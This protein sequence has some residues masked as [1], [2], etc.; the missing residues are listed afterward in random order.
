MAGLIALVLATRKRVVAGH[1]A[2]VVDVYA[3]FL[4]AFV[5][6]ARAFL[7]AALLAAGIISARRQ[8][9][10]FDHLVHVAAAAFDCGLL[11]AWRAIAQV[12]FAGAVMWMGGLATAQCLAAGAVAER[13]RVEAGLA[14]FQ[15]D[16][17]L[18]AG[19][20]GRLFGACFA[21]ATFADVAAVLALV[22]AA[23]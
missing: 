11:V 19:T 18:A 10:A 22:I 5:L 20:G 17:H 3:A 16:R 14:L 8:L 1:R 2:D 4:I 7:Y 15:D 12:A 9:S 21:W 23:T 13:N 6:S